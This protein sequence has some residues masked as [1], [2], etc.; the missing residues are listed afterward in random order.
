MTS[1]SHQIVVAEP[2]SDTAI[3]RLAEYGEVA[4]LEACDFSTL[5]GAVADCEALLVRSS[6]R[7]TDSVIAAAKRLRVIGR[8]GA[9]LDNIALEAAR[10]RGIAVVYTPAAATEAVAD[11]TVGLMLAL[12][13][14][15]CF[16]DA[17]VRD[18]RFAEAREASIG[19]ELSELSIGVVGFGRIGRA[20][21]RRCRQGF[22]C[23]IYVNDIVEPGRTEFTVNRKTKEELYSSADIVT[24]HV[25]LTE[26]THHLINRRTLGLFKRGAFLVNTA[27]G[28]V[29]ERSSLVDALVAGQLGGAALDVFE[30]EPISA[31]DPLLGAPHT[32]L[33][34]HIG[35]RT[36]RGLDRMNGVVD[37]VI[38][39]LR[40]ETPT[41]P[42]PG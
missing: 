34:P 15:T 6:A 37:D 1:E 26:R 8:G 13:R 23:T 31:D 5:V 30:K 36:V 12:V 9:G 14:G 17:A 24:L 7:V 40:G 39:V 20:V 38:R 22:G 32:L 19:R 10:S 3:S 11:L 25:P 16:A 4:C 2:Y 18:G 29:V 21:A 28:A 41:F 33:T 27:R 42:A 35:A